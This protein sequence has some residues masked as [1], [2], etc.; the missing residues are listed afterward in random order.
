MSNDDG[1]YWILNDEISDFVIFNRSFMPKI[2]WNAE[3]IPEYVMSYIQQFRVPRKN[4]VLGWSSLL[5][6]VC[7]P[8]RNLFPHTYATFMYALRLY[9][10]LGCRFLYAAYFHAFTF[11]FRINKFPAFSLSLE[12]P[13]KLSR[14]Q[15]PVSSL[16]A[17]R[18]RL[19]GHKFTKI[20]RPSTY[21]LNVDAHLLQIFPLVHLR[22]SLL[23]PLSHPCERPPYT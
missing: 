12:V 22:S 14:L 21:A 4:P 18:I 11:A 3:S 8:G 20:P 2:T 7:H 15:R 1:Q 13:R 6:S 10:L 9:E 16:R 17:M 5:T 19:L 23:Y